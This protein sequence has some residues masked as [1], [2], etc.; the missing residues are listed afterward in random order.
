MQ[1]YNKIVN[2]L[3]KTVSKLRSLAE[4]NATRIKDHADQISRL[5]ADKKGFELEQNRSISTADKIE[6]LLT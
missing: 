5:D 2:N 3:L 1:N 4:Y 6:G